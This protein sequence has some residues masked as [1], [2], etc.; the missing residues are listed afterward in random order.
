M[1]GTFHIIF[2]GFSL[3]LSSSVING[4]VVS[5]VIK[6]RGQNGSHMIALG[7]WSRLRLHISVA[8]I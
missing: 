5:H 2:K 6:G 3:N 1:P 7:S 8:E 4:G